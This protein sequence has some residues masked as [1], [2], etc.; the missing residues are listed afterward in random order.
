M[1]MLIGTT[2]FSHAATMESAVKAGVI[3]N[4]AKYIEWPESIDLY[5]TFNICHNGDNRLEDSLQ[6]LQ[7]KLIGGK[8]ISVKQN[9]KPED[10][11]SC[12]I[13]FI[14]EDD[15]QVTYKLLHDIGN[16]PIVTVSDSPKFVLKGGMI[17][18]IRDGGRVGFE[19]NLAPVNVKDL[20]FSA[21]LLKLAKVVKGL[22]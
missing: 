21:Q 10:F 19:V 12:Q 20:H 13:L 8:H 11:Y 6:A 1:A 7:G 2:K 16:A 18:I 5:A 14:A 17:G 4:F 15:D 22:K 9:V 3:Y